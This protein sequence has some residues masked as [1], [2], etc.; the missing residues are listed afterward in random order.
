[1][2]EALP[3]E[4]LRAYPQ[5]L[6][7]GARAQVLATLERGIAHGDD[8]PGGDLVLKELRRP[9]RNTSHKAQ[10]MGDPARL[11][12]APFEPFLVDDAET[13]PAGRIAR[14]ALE[15]IWQWLCRDLLPANAK[16][17]GEEVGRALSDENTAARLARAFQDLAALHIQEALAAAGED[18][19]AK[20]RLAGQVGAP[21]ALD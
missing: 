10:R 15:P 6:K 9:F 12:F 11:F 8:I 17:Y 1:M 3:V 7:P 21:R 19:R 14:T 16:A 20:R 5:E 4:R 18:E 2:A 13:A